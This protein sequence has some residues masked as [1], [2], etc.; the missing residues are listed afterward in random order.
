[1]LQKKQKNIN[2]NINEMRFFSFAAAAA[3]HT[4]HISVSK[5]L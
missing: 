4:L 5:I 2:E 3:A 1:V